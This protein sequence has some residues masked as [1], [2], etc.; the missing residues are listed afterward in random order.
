[1]SEYLH[2]PKVTLINTALKLVK[3]TIS[4]FR[5]VLRNNENVMMLK[6]RN[7]VSIYLKIKFLQSL[8]S[9]IFLLLSNYEI[10]DATHLT[11]FIIL[12]SSLCMHFD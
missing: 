3:L 1:M 11:I 10:T 2:K 12:L 5:Y 4:V 7:S 8:V 9:C 6:T